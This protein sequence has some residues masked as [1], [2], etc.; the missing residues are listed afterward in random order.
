MNGHR[1]GHLADETDTEAL[2]AAIARCL[3]AT[4]IISLDGDLG[5]GKTTLVRGLLRALGH[6]GPVRSPTYTLVESYEVGG[7]R[8]HHLDL[9]RV[10]DPEELEFLGLRDLL[11]PPSV[12]LVE[13]AERGA[14]VLPSADIEI[15]L[16][17]SGS[18]REATA[19]ASGR[20]GAAMLKNLM[21]E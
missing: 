11:S 15:G 10:A 16:S 14:G 2:G 19:R 13:W 17:V 20:V 21:S 5:A 12:L 3:P 1:L 18:G 9:Y 4:V 6:R 8:L 7:Y